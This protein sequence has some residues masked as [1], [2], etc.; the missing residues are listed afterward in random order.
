[1]QSVPLADVKPPVGIPV[2]EI[3]SVNIDVSICSP[4]RGH[5]KRKRTASSPQLPSNPPSSRS[6]ADQQHVENL[7]ILSDVHVGSEAS[8]L[9]VYD[10][11]MSHDNDFILFDEDLH[12]N[13]GDLFEDLVTGQEMIMSQDFESELTDEQ[14]FIQECLFTTQQKPEVDTTVVWRLL[15]VCIRRAISGAPLHTTFGIKTKKSLEDRS[16][17]DIA[18]ALFSPGYLHVSSTSLGSKRDHLRLENPLR[19]NKR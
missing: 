1:M 11:K 15:D 7:S 18:P 13:W 5:R 2:I 14:N 12:N 3:V 4:P 17:A 19:R 6:T 16:L 10:R 8:I 9:T